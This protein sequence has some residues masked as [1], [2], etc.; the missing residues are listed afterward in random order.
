M[1]FVSVTFLGLVSLV[2]FQLS[3]LLL[4]S[5]V[6]KNLES[7]KCANISSVIGILTKVI[8]LKIYF[9]ML[10]AFGHLIFYN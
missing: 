10:L 3:T 9:Q 5:K 7:C 1:Y 4:K 6:V 8:T 2:L